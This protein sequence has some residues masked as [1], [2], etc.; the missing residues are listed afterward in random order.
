MADPRGSHRTDRGLRVRGG[1]CQTTAVEEAG[2]G[3]RAGIFE[4]RALEDLKPPQG[5]T[6]RD[7][8][9]RRGGSSNSSSVSQSIKPPGAPLRAHTVHG[10]LPRGGHCCRLSHLILNSVVRLCAGSQIAAG[11]G[12]LS[13]VGSG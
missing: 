10:W 8:G 13:S 1:G 2:A 3:G 12:S 7:D 4:E 9:E 5:G 11:N 6:S